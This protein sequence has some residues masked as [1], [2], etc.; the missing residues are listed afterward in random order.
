MRSPT[1]SMKAVTIRTASLPND[2]PRR[3]LR[4]GGSGEDRD[5]RECT[6]PAEARESPAA[7]RAA[8]HAAGA[9]PAESPT[10]AGTDTARGRRW[11]MELA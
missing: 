11:A 10:S 4:G 1:M 6:R 2:L 3:H 9:L 5:A 7:R 8:A